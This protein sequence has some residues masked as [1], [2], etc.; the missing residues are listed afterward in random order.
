MY[1][2]VIRCGCDDCDGGVVVVDDITIAPLLVSLVLLSGMW[3]LLRLPVVLSFS[4]NVVACD[5]CGCG[6]F[7]DIVFNVVA[8]GNA[9]VVVM[10]CASCVVVHRCCLLSCCWYWCLCLC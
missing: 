9:V 4:T 10:R 8:V 2:V 1:A 5:I 6:Y 7:G 3:L